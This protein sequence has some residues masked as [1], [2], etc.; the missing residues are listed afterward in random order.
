M[1]TMEHVAIPRR[2]IPRRR[3]FVPVVRTLGAV[4]GTNEA[5]EHAAVGT[6]RARVEL[7]ATPGLGIASLADASEESAR[8]ASLM[9]RAQRQ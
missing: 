7:S 6:T 5:L 8:Y 2:S 1:A 3:P 4:E 9:R